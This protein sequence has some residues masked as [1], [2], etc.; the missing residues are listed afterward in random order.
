M[1]YKYQ[2][3][4]PK[5]DATHS[6]KTRDFYFLIELQISYA[7]NFIVS[8]TVRGWNA[9]GYK[10]KNI[11]FRFLYLDVIRGANFWSR[12]WKEVPA[13]RTRNKIPLSKEYLTKRKTGKKSFF[14][15]NP[16]SPPPLCSNIPRKMSE[17]RG[18]IFSVC[19]S[20]ESTG[21]KRFFPGMSSDWLPDRKLIRRTCLLLYIST[22][23][24]WRLA[25]LI[26]WYIQI[27]L[28][29]NFAYVF[30]SISWITGYFLLI[31]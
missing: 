21:I 10:R 25:N 6:F 20:L 24:T 8:I 16:P 18:I 5:T 2:L 9:I 13:H 28:L 15:P 17:N 26:A 29:T 31:M 11:P 14:F 7:H 19:F 3:P 1:A 27:W 12:Y 4:D 30:G 23:P 22:L